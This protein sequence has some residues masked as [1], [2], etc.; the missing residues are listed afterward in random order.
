VKGRI[1]T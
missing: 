1:K